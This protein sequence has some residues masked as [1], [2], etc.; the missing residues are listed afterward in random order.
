[1]TLGQ[2]VGTYRED[3][4]MSNHI[5]RDVRCALGFFWKLHQVSNLVKS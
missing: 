2:G 1:M 4:R 3:W 5:Y